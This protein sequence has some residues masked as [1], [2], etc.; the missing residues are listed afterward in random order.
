MTSLLDQPTSAGTRR[1]AGRTAAL[2]AVAAGLA[3]TLAACGSDAL[4]LGDSAD[5]DFYPLD[6]GSEANGSGTVTV[7]DVREGSVAELE[8]GGFSIDAD[9]QDSTPYYVDVTFEN[10]GDAPVEP[11]SPGGEDP[12]EN[13]I[14]A[15]A[16]I[17]LGGP[18]YEPCPGIP[19][20]VAPGETAEGCAIVLVPDGIELER[21]SYFT[22][23]TDDDF[24]YWEAGL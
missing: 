20:K 21:I 17:D 12:D 16:V 8:E 6:G 14:S 2:L 15:L 19:E 10:D 1:P 11:R 18:A 3:A 4:A 22:G 24:I 7:T 5:I 9:Q 23:G 13:L